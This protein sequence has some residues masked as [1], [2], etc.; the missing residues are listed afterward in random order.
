[1]PNETNLRLLIQGMTPELDSKPYG[2][3]V[4]KA[5]LNLPV[6][7]CFATIREAEGLTLVGRADI[8]LAA[9][10]VLN[11]EWAHITLQ[12]HSSLEAIGLTAAFAAALGQVGVS[13]NVIAGFHHDHIFVQWDKRDA[14]MAALIALSHKN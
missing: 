14:A 8:L 9:G 4:A 7:S 11:S 13:A 6:E 2:Y 5:E 1:M 3:V 12:I 10:Y